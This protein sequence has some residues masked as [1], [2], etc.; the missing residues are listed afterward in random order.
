MMAVQVLVFQSP[1]IPGWGRTEQQCRMTR[2][3]VKIDIYQGPNLQILSKGKKYRIKN[4]NSVVEL[5]NS[6][7]ELADACE[8]PLHIQHFKLLLVAASH[9]KMGKQV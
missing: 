2:F 1:E 8:C 9:V 3:F 7:H 5:I 4:C 6:I